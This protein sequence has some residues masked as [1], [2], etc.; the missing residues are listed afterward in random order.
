MVCYFQK[1]CVSGRIQKLHSN[2]KVSEECYINLISYKEC[3]VLVYLSVDFEDRGKKA[4]Q[5]DKT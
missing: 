4:K 5:H 3:K 1:L 2:F